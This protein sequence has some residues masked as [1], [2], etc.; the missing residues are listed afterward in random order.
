MNY[1]KNC[2]MPDTKPGVSLNE[3]GICNACRS[4]EKNRIDWENQYKKLE[5]IAKNAKKK[6]ILFMTAL[7]L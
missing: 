6:T 1:C 2:V 5:E 7:F 3:K 4:V